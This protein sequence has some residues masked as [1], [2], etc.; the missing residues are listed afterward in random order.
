MDLSLLFEINAFLCLFIS[1]HK[2]QK[3]F[4]LVKIGC[5]LK[6]IKSTDLE[7]V[8]IFFYLLGA[9]TESS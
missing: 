3:L 1:L 6:K 7:V 5:G 9:V 2:S 4:L 8:A